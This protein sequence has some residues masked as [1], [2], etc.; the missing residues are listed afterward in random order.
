M[1]KRSGSDL[2]ATVLLGLATGTTILATTTAHGSVIA[3]LA[4]S[5]TH[6][7]L[8]RLAILATGTTH[9]CVVTTSDWSVHVFYIVP[10]D[11]F[12]QDC[13]NKSGE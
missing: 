13:G 4:T 12:T 11:F 7:I 3:G 10:L 6:S 2:I 9:G 8:T 5:T 1:K